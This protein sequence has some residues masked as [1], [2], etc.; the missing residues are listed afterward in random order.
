MRGDRKSSASSHRTRRL[1][2]SA[3]ETGPRTGERVPED[4]ICP[5][6]GEDP[7]DVV[8]CLPGPGL[9]YGA[10]GGELGYLKADVIPRQT[11]RECSVRLGGWHHVACFVAE[12]SR[13]GR[14]ARWR[15]FPQLIG[16]RHGP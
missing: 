1:L 15:R 14:F 2:R 11:C 8:T 5:R 13:C 7:F 10:E 4:W 9:P 6:C 12:C 3:R 16:C